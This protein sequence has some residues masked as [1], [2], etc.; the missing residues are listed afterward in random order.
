[1]TA[2]DLKSLSDD[3]L[4]AIAAGAAITPLDVD[5]FN[6]LAAPRH[7]YNSRAHRDECDRLRAELH[8]TDPVTMTLAE[9]LLGWDPIASSPR[10][11]FTNGRYDHY[12]SD[13]LALRRLSVA[14]KVVGAATGRSSR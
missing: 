1:M 4:Q 3:Q 14:A 10:G 13:L 12:P 8:G 6:P 2:D 11:T 7:E 9:L 5:V